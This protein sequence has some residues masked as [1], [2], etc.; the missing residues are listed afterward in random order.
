MPAVCTCNACAAVHEWLYAFPGPE[1]PL[2]AA[3]TE[4]SLVLG[5]HVTTCAV[6]LSGRRIVLVEMPHLSGHARTRFSM[7]SHARRSMLACL[8]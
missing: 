2:V 7:T 6:P 5:V 8:V 1:W 3:T 4:L